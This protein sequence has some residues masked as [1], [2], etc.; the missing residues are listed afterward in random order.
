MSLYGSLIAGVS[1]LKAQT[2]SMSTISDNIAT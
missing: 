2:Q 1:G